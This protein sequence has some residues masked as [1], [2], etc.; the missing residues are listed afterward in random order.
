[1]YCVKLSIDTDFLAQSKTLIISAKS[2]FIVE[3]IYKPHTKIVKMLVKKLSIFVPELLRSSIDSR[4]R[5]NSQISVENLLNFLARLS[6]NE[7]SASILFD[8]SISS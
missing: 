4:S 8:G 5:I 3:H 1:M 7:A 6:F 2:M